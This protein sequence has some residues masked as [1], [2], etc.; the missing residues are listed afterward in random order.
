[1][2]TKRKMLGISSI[3]KTY[4]NRSDIIKKTMPVA[5]KITVIALYLMAP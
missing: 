1:M 3:R 2:V 4:Q 5:I